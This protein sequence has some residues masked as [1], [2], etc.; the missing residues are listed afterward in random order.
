MPG[1]EISPGLSFSLVPD[2]IVLGTRSSAARGMVESQ[3]TSSDGPRDAWGDRQDIR[4]RPLHPLKAA[5]ARTADALG[6]TGWS[7]RRLLERYGCYIRAVNYHDV[8]AAHA[9]GLERQMRW[10]AQHFVPV[11]ATELSELLAGRWQATR[12]GLLIS[13][14]D[15]WRCQARVAAPI[16]ERYGWRGWFLVPVGF[17]D[18]PRAEFVRQQPRGGELT[19]MSWD[20]LRS[21]DRQGHVVGCHTYSHHTLPPDTPTEVRERELVY[22]K[23][24]L[25]TELGHPIETFSWVWGREGDYHAL[26]AR[27]I[28]QAGYRQAFLTTP[29]LIHP[30]DNPTQLPRTNVEARFPLWLVRYQLSGIPD[31]LGSAKRHRIEA[32]LGA[33]S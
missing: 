9:D 6:L 18:E 8:I 30:G 12:P 15:G 16:L 20:E 31:V 22:A 7:L 1:T 24:R 5:L 14:D 13:F 29:G 11:G 4:Y 27:A 17:L 10:Y 28:V 33:S 23:R 25:E 32:R 21:L 26:A 3:S 2:K 19:P